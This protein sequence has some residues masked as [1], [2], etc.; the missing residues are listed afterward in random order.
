MLHPFQVT[1]PKWVSTLGLI[2]LGALI[3][4]LFRGLWSIIVD[5]LSWPTQTWLIACVVVF[6]WGMLTGTFAWVVIPGRIKLT[7]DRFMFH[8]N[9][10]VET[11]EGNLSGK[12]QALQDLVSDRLQDEDDDQQRSG[13]YWLAA[14]A[15]LL[16]ERMISEEPIPEGYCK[17][18]H[19]RIAAYDDTAPGDAARYRKEDHGKLPNGWPCPAPYMYHLV[20]QRHTQIEIRAKSKT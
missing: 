13:E 1:A 2:G 14:V 19:E 12:L 11:L 9:L 15:V 6:L 5:G 7:L 3:P 10:R 18:C 4:P 17:F 16:L 8:M 20:S